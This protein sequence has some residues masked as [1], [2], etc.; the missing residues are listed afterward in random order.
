MKNVVALNWINKI[1]EPKELI[2]NI[3]KLIFT[4]ILMSLKVDREAHTIKGMSL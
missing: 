3:K 4:Q 1:N 2:K